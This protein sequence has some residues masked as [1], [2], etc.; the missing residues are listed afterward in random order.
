MG[1]FCVWPSCGY[2]QHYVIRRQRV[3]SSKGW[4]ELVERVFLMDN[5]PFPGKRTHLGVQLVHR[6]GSSLKRHNRRRVSSTNNTL[7]TFYPKGLCRLKWEEYDRTFGLHVSSQ[8]EFRSV[9]SSGARHSTAAPSR[10]FLLRLIT[11][12]P[13]F[14]LESRHLNAT[15]VKTGND[16]GSW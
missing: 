16:P 2:A 5:K 15:R 7:Y 1:V 14:R 12:V 9:G 3:K 10:C 13:C 8:V 6:H 11:L 4:S